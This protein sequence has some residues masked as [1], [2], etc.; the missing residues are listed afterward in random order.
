MSTLRVNNIQNE[1]GGDLINAK[2]MANAW[3]NFNGTG[4]V[5][6]SATVHS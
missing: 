6:I 3:V 4:T 2:G 5:N 1:A